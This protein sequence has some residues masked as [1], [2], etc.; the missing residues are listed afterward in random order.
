MNVI[1]LEQ[2][3]RDAMLDLV[4]AWGTLDGALGMLL[5]TA[6]GLPLDKGAAKF[7]RSNNP[8]KLKK[9]CKWLRELPRGADTANKLE[10]HVSLYEKYSD[11][12]NCIAH[13]KCVGADGDDPDYI[14]FLKFERYADD[15]LLCGKYLSA[16]YEKQLNGATPVMLR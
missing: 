13:S 8:D 3:H 9:L 5:S 2:H 11:P 16:K 15:Q 10:K 1:P 12:R 4:L 7:G 14:V 6:R